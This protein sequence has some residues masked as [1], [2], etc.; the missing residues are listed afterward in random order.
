MNRTI[1]GFYIYRLLRY[2]YFHV[3]IGLVYFQSVGL[4]LSAAL[5]L[6][7]I[8]YISKAIFDVPGGYFADNIGRK[9]S[10]V[11]S[12]LLCSIAYMLIGTN[13]EYTIFMLAE[14]LL[15]LAMSISISSDS[16]LIY[17]ELE[18]LGQIDKYSKIES[19]GWALR[20]L[21]FGLASIVGAALAL[22][23]PLSVSFILSSMTILISTII[24]LV[25]ISE[26][27]FK[28]R[29]IKKKSWVDSIK[30]TLKEPEAIP[31][32]LIFSMLFVSIRIGFWAFQPVLMDLNID[33]QYFGLLFGLSLFLTTVSTRYTE[34]L[35]RYGQYE[36][37]VMLLLAGGSMILVSIGLYLNDSLLII[38][39]GFALHAFMQG[40]YDPKM[41]TKINKI[42][43][44]DTRASIIS[45]AIMIGN[46][47]FAV[48]APLYGF[49]SENYGQSISLL[50]I[51]LP[52]VVVGLVLILKKRLLFIAQ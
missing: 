49:L 26:P 33:I 34:I 52:L 51:S 31:L 23:V 21:G 9:I 35:S 14:I 43:T 27:S 45:I 30:A 24:A 15:G 5:S 48:V 3:A 38:S 36:Q 41:R 29:T 17:D 44:T 25:Y 8:Y 40:I 46:I 32:L 28:K 11:L 16:A 42:S 47:G 12:G 2:S 18:N 39:I 19:N 50:S 10:L 20:N 13:E 1:Y 7:S 4:S 22:V 37:Y 6:E